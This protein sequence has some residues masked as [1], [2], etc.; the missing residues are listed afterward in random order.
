[1]GALASNLNSTSVDQTEIPFTSHKD[2]LHGS[3]ANKLT[4]ELAYGAKVG[5]GLEASD[6]STGNID[7]SFKW[8]LEQ[9]EHC[10]SIVKR[11][12][13]IRLK[14]LE[15]RPGPEHTDMLEDL[16]WTAIRAD[17]MHKPCILRDTTSGELITRGFAQLDSLSKGADEP[18]RERTV[19]KQAL[20]EPLA[21]TSIIEHLRAGEQGGDRHKRMLERLLFDNQDDASSFGKSAEFYLAWVRTYLPYILFDGV[22]PLLSYSDV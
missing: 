1:M 18:G 11:A 9:S 19:L 20:A 15:Q 13:R 17:L 7:G 2:Q 21:I 3:S 12:L 22:S 14:Q 5:I 4:E 10:Q 8:I 16:Y 6:T